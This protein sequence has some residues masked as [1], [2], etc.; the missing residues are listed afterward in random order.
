MKNHLRKDGLH[1]N[2]TNPHGEQ[3]SRCSIA[4]FAWR[5]GQSHR[6]S[7]AA[8][9]RNN[10]YTKWGVKRLLCR[11]Q[12]WCTRY[13]YESRK[14]DPITIDHE[15]TM[16]RHLNQV[17]ACKHCDR[18][19]HPN[20]RCTEVTL[21]NKV[22]FPKPRRQLTRKKAR[23]TPSSNSSQRMKNN[24]LVYPNQLL[25]TMAKQSINSHRRTRSL[26]QSDNDLSIRML[27]SRS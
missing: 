2:S 16:V 17:R 18:K 13:Q 10:W 23:T 11:H 20:Q 21:K 12:Q 1:I 7:Y 15:V 8:V 27:T 3:C 4:W 24:G 9:W 25:L 22:T 26:K 19:T 14:T 5:D 6:K